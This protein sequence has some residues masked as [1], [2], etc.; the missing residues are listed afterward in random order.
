[1]ILTSGTLHETLT[2]RDPAVR[3]EAWETLTQYFDRAE[4]RDFCDV[5]WRI[6]A[7]S[8]LSY[9]WPDC[10]EVILR[11][12][13][14]HFAIEHVVRGI[15]EYPG[16]ALADLLGVRPG[17]SD[18]EP[19]LHPW[20]RAQIG[21]L[22]SPIEWVREGAVQQLSADPANASVLRIL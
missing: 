13:Q 17:L 6:L 22:D 3:R 10:R 19:D 1:M 16:G 11:T 20:T 4:I 21:L 15:V 5:L 2:D 12:V 14:T 8:G 18:H 7:D 9:A